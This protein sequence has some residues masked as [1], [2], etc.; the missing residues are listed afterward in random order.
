MGTDWIS[1]ACLLCCTFT[2]VGLAAE[3]PS[4][5]KLGP[6]RQLFIDDYVIAE[7]RGVK[8]VLNQPRKHPGNPLVTAEHPWEGD[9]VYFYGSVVHDEA[10][11]IFKM[12]YQGY[13]LRRGARGCYATSRD[14]IQWDKPQLGLVDFKGSKANN[15][16]PWSALGMIHAPDD[17]D[18]SRRYRS[19]AGRHGRFSADGLRWKRPEG[20]KDIPGDLASD[21]VIPFCY[22]DLG[23]R[24]VAFPKVVRKS[25]KHSRR[26]VS[27]AMSDDFLTWT[28]AKAVLVPDARD[29]ALARERISAM[30]D[31]VAHDDGPDWHLA[32]FYGMSGFPYEGMYLGMLW[33][34][35]ISGWPPGKKRVAGIGGE[36]GV[37][38][39]ELAS[40]R[41][42]LD[43]ERVCD[44]EVFL[45]VGDAGTWEG[46][47]IYMP[48]RPVI[49]GDEIW[50][51]YSA[52]RFSHAHPIGQGK[53]TPE[54]D[55][56]VAEAK[57]GT[58]GG[59]GAIGLATLRLD[60]WVSVDAGPEGGSVTTKAL[61]FEA[62]RKLVINAAARQGSVAVEILDETGKPLPGFAGSDCDV[63]SGDAIRHTVTWNGRAGLSELAGKP[64]SLRFVLKNAKLYSFVF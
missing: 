33:V 15:R 8:Q 36:D 42:L 61:V 3:R 24:Y 13:T 49:V 26:S 34:F 22:D 20:S 64:V 59:L 6:H 9:L 7:M 39:V 46:A 12:W 43:W 55:R 51:Y 54:T 40:S 29:D 48:N 56:M 23:D 27:V 18:P 37:I 58:K 28:K 53:P 25:R 17:P 63:F 16:I 45:P 47:I 10:Q 44:R 14:G 62:G 31:H 32:Q 38:Q 50:I 4:P 52:Y 21:N 11:K 57:A 5:I 1:V 19:L 2:S 30:R 60:G 41:D 35:D